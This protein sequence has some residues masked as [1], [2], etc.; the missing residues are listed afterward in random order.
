MSMLDEIEARLVAATPGPW[1]NEGAG[2]VAQ[3]WS[4]PSPWGPVVSTEVSCG[5]Y[6]LGG[7]SKG[8]VND[9]DAD[10]IAHA[11]TDLAALVAVVRVAQKFHQPRTHLD[12]SGATWQVCVGCISYAGLHQPWPCD[13]GRALV[14]LEEARPAQHEHQWIDVCTWE[15]HTTDGHVWKC[16]GCGAEER[17]A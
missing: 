5:S 12:P 14:E 4:R 10:L 7:S 6:C 13:I 2:E 3:H 8:V 15:D 17:R 9:A 16:H 11:P 1:E